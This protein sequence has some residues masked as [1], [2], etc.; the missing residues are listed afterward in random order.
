MGHISVFEDV[1]RY[2]DRVQDSGRFASTALV[3]YYIC[4]QQYDFECFELFL[5]W[6]DDSG[7][8]EALPEAG[9]R[10][11]EEQM[12]RRVAYDEQSIVSERHIFAG[13]GNFCYTR[14]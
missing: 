10:R 4:G 7:I 14:S 3:G 13:D 1:S 9:N 5:V 11:K 6:E 12:T 8:D 2:L